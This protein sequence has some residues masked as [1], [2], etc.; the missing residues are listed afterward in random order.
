[1]IMDHWKREERQ[2]IKKYGHTS[3]PQDG[4]FETVYFGKF[5]IPLP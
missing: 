3:L 2:N 5:N 1:M 4:Y